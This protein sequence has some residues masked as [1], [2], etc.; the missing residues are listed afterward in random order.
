MWDA[1]MFI[2]FSVVESF[3]AFVLTLTIFRLKALDFQWQALVVSLLMSLQSFVLREELDLAFLAP[4]IN[5][6]LMVLLITTVVKVPLIWSCILSVTG[7]FV[8][9]LV[10]TILLVLMYSDTPMSELQGGTAMGSL[11]QAITSAVVL[12]A[13]GLLYKFGIGFIA[14]FDK[15]RFKWEQNLV[16]VVIIGALVTVTVIAYL[17]DVWLNIAYFAMAAGLFLYYALKKEREYD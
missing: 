10:Q 16:I 7:F 13:S 11:L 5:I 14:P 1:S 9:T 8:Y 3:T 12:I 4:V 2:T 15:L 6:L 17:N